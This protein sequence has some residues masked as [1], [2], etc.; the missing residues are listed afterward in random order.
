MKYKYWGESGRGIFQGNIP[1][2]KSKERNIS[3]RIFGAPVEKKV[4]RVTVAYKPVARKRPR[5]KE[6]DKSCCYATAR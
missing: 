1:I 6:G 4:L 5:N 3:S 2:F